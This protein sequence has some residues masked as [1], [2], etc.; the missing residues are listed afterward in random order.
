MATATGGRSWGRCIRR[1]ELIR[2]DPR[3]PRHLLLGP[4]PTFRPGCAAPDG[5]LTVVS[6]VPGPCPVPAAHRH[7]S[8]VPSPSHPSGEETDLQGCSRRP[9]PPSPP[10]PRSPAGRCHPRAQGRPNQRPRGGGGGGDWPLQVV[11]RCPG[12]CCWRGLD[13]AGCLADARLSLSEWLPGRPLAG[14]KGPRAV[15]LRGWPHALTPI[16]LVGWASWSPL[17]TGGNRGP[18][19]A[20][21]SSPAPS[22]GSSKPACLALCRRPH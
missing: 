20:A 11:Q 21:R 13:P 16:T 19:L 18:E 3:R 2:I 14:Q 12:L 4:R 7:Q 6:A 10:A 15:K 8:P 5:P 17:H 1:H 22:P 9:G